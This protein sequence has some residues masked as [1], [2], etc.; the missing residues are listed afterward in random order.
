[1][2][3]KLSTKH[4]P[5]NGASKFLSTAGR[6]IFDHL[7]KTG[8]TAVNEWLQTTLGDGCASPKITTIDH[9]SL[10]AKF[11]GTYSV[12]T[13]HVKFDGQGMYPRYQYVTLLREPTDRMMSWLYSVVNKHTAAELGEYWHVAKK[14]IESD[15]DEGGDLLNG[16]FYVKHFAEIDGVN[17]AD[18]RSL[19]DAAVG[20]LERFDVWGI[21]EVMPEVLADFSGL[22][23]VQAPVCLEPVNVTRERPN[24]G[25]LGDSIRARIIEL[26]SLDIEFYSMMKDRYAAAR[27]RWSHR[28]GAGIGLKPMPAPLVVT[29]TAEEFTIHSARIIGGDSV[30]AQGP[31]DFEVAFSLVRPVSNLN[32][33]LVVRDEVGAHIFSKDSAAIGQPIGPLA[34]ESF[35][36]RFTFMANLPDGRYTLGLRVGEELNGFNRYIAALDELAVFQIGSMP[37]HIPEPTRFQLPTTIHCEAVPTKSG[38]EGWRLAAS[39]PRLHSH[40]GRCEGG[41]VVS[42]GRSG[43]LL[44]GPYMALFE[45]EWRATLE[46]IPQPDAGILRIEVASFGGRLVHASLEVTNPTERAQLGFRLEHPVLDIEVRVWVHEL[47]V[48]RIDAIVVE[49]AAIEGNDFSVANTGCDGFN[50]I[51]HE[52]GDNNGFNK[53]QITSVQ[54]AMAAADS[55]EAEVVTSGFSFRGDDKRAGGAAARGA[56]TVGHATVETRNDLFYGPVGYNTLAPDR[57]SD[58]GCDEAG[59]PREEDTLNA[60][61]GRSQRASAENRL[62][63]WPHPIFSIV[64]ANDGRSAALSELLDVL[65]FLEGPPLEVCVVRGPTEDGSA[66]VLAA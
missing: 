2:V 7:Q 49:G 51:S 57:E 23:G 52:R 55:T 45:G 30:A 17:L 25:D 24:I 46:G 8:G 26:N 56:A 41:S 61:A 16:N 64:I 12:L 15:G 43:F 14:F 58:Q 4:D 28:I 37:R 44:Y 53:G 50:G 59:K 11:G 20:A 47:S 32:I 31:I 48:A 5:N 54:E 62:T 42:D 63:P 29:H 22:L 65:S 9:R 35:G 66:E 38:T 10:V 6:V 27:S 33:G 34:A 19:I 21:Y 18:G 3:R 36:T 60:R 40:V 1:M 13:A 39:D